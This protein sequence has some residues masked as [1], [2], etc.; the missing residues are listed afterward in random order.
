M[1]ELDAELLVHAPARLGHQ[2]ERV[3]RR[4]AAGVLDE[5]RV[6]RRD[7]GAADPVALRARTASISRPGAALAGAGS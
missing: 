2:R 1:L 5:V 7:Q 6:A 3:G 4:R